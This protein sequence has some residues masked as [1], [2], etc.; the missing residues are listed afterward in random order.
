MI[1]K[2]LG[3]VISIILITLLLH[4]VGLS[5]GMVLDG[6]KESLKVFNDFVEIIKS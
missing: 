2:I 3:V 1:K 4:F 6:V 5:W